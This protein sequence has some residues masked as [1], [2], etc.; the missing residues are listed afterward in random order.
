MV[1]RRAKKKLPRFVR[2]L[3]NHEERIN[4]ALSYDPILEG[5]IGTND[6]QSREYGWEEYPFLDKV[7]IDGILYSHYFSGGVMGRPISG[8]NV[9]RALIYKNG[10]SCTQGHSHTFDYAVRHNANGTVSHGLCV[11]V[12]QDYTPDYA[13]AQ[14][15]LWHRGVA[16]KRNVADGNYD[17]QWISMDNLK[18]EYGKA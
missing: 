7:E 9:G 5:T 14:G 18:A 12:F 4:R 11:G 2:T 15:H 17:L 1:L 8:D 16:I 6:L 3:G 13:K 10:S